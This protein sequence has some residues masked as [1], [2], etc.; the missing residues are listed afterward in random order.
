MNFVLIQLKFKVNIIKSFTQKV[1]FFV[2][3]TKEN[4]L[5]FKQL[6]LYSLNFFILTGNI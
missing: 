6:F 1:K 4:Q 2:T 5:S 3:Q